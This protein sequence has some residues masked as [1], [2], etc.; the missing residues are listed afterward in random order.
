MKEIIYN[1]AKEFKIYQSEH[2][3]NCE[4]EFERLFKISKVDKNLNSITVESIEKQEKKLNSTKKV[5]SKYKG[6]RLFLII[7]CLIS[8]LT[9]VI[10]FYFLKDLD[11]FILY[12]SIT[13]SICVI[14]LISFLLLI[15]LRINKLIKNLS[16]IVNKIQLEI[17]ELTQKAWEQMK[18][19]NNLFYSRIS[20]KL[21][22]STL[23]LVKFDNYLQ[24]TKLNFFK[25]IGLKD[26]ES[27]K[28]VVDL[29]SG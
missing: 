9:P 5:I 2:Q 4:K 25:S 8:I 26:L 13:I 21:I 19:L 29:S 28:T 22:E 16:T 1:P 17:N 18:S 10:A 23:G 14:L 15:F 27:D 7:M 11:K 3:L 20:K 6:L 12:I 24:N